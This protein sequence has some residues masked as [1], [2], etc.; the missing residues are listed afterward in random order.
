MQLNSLEQTILQMLL[1]GDDTVLALLRTQREAA[2]IVSRKM[3]GVGFFI[4]FA[5]PESIERTTPQHFVIG[6]VSGSL[7]SL[8]NGAGFLL[9]IKNGVLSC[10]EGY[11][12]NEG[13]PSEPRLTEVYYIHHVPADS[14]RML[15]CAVRDLK[16]LRAN[17]SNK[18]GI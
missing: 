10:L 3:T 14:P 17:W 5:V 2:T 13:W 15:R 4:H 6:D 18:Q 8:A 11:T 1:A 9:F 7:S 16:Q 12:Y